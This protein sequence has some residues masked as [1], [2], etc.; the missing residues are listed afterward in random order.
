MHSA[1]FAR[2]AR[3]RLRRLACGLR[4]AACGLR[5][6]AGGLRPAAGWAGLGRGLGWAGM[7][8]RAC[9]TTTRY[10]TETWIGDNFF[11]F[12]NQNSILQNRCHNF[13]RCGIETHFFFVGT[14]A[15]ISIQIPTCRCP[16]HSAASRE[17]HSNTH[18]KHTTGCSGLI[19]G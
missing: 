3:S 5:P 18:N 16:P 9:T 14:L 8:V 1:G 13:A 7:R 4:P 11:H 2:S 6:A 10:E 17:N 12:Q 15:E 19:P